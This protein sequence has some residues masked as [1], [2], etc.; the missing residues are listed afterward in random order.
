MFYT[1]SP[2]SVYTF[3]QCIQVP[4]PKHK[5]LHCISLISLVPTSQPSMIRLV[6]FVS[7]PFV[8]FSKICSFRLFYIQTVFYFSSKVVWHRNKPFSSTCPWHSRCPIYASMCWA[9]VWPM[10]FITFSIHAPVLVQ[11]FWNQEQETINKMKSAIVRTVGS[12]RKYIKNALWD[13]QYEHSRQDG[14]CV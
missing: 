8:L 9:H 14:A 11:H 12:R 10:S 3:V 6:L 5:V 7:Q 4:C 1:K 2:D 13:S